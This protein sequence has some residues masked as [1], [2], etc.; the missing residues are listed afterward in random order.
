M[1]TVTTEDNNVPG[2]TGDHRDGDLVIMEDVSV[3]DGVSQPD[4]A[5]Y[6]GRDRVSS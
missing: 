5:L 3:S 6:F 1:A 2:Q 4:D